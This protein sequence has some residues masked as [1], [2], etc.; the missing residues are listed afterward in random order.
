MKINYIAN[1]RI[2][3]EKANGFQIMKMCEAFADYGIDLEL[4]VPYRKNH[5]KD[6]PFDFYDVKNNFKI[7]KIFCLDLVKFG[8]LGFFI[9]TFSFLIFVK[10]YSFFNFK[11]DDIIYTREH[12]TRLFFKEIIFEDHQPRGP[13]CLY[14]FFLKKNSKKIVVAFNLEKLYNIFNIKPDSYIICPNGVELEKFKNTKIDKNIWQK[15]FNFSDNQRIVLYVG[16]FYKWKGVYIL[17]QAARLFKRK[18]VKFVL[19]GG[20]KKDQKAIKEYLEKNHINNVFVKE[21]VHHKEI[22]KYIKSAD[23]LVL[24]NTAKEERS[25][26]Y[27]TPIKLFEYMAS[28]VPIVASK[29]ESFSRYLKDGEEVLFFKADDQDD[30]ARKIEKVLD[31]TELSQYI[32]NN[33]F[34]AVSKYTWK[35]RIEKIINFIKQCK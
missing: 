34:K 7:K 15:E 5:L 22:I 23:A 20:T 9:Q 2:P 27:T 25:S 30:L 24:P 28:G 3:T 19:I 26:K 32:S 8:K 1:A 10:M 29:L 31:D 11:R 14:E 4:I 21:F 16:H 13:R 33:A 17:L 6:D 18:D 35:N 12:F